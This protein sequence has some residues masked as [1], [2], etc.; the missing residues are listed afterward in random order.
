M[1]LGRFTTE[2]QVLNHLCKSKHPR[3]S[4]SIINRS[5]CSG[6][7]W[8]LPI[9]FLFSCIC[10]LVFW[11]VC[12][13]FSAF[14]L[15]ERSVKNGIS[16]DHILEFI[17]SS[18]SHFSAEKKI[19]MLLAVTMT[20]SLCKWQGQ[21]LV[22][23]MRSLLAYSWFVGQKKNPLWPTKREFKAA[24][25]SRQQILWC[26]CFNR[27][28][29]CRWHHFL[30]M[31]CVEITQSPWMCLTEPLLRSTAGLDKKKKKKLIH[32]LSHQKTSKMS[33]ERWRRLS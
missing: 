18:L 4:Q 5:G 8:L 20:E 30:R 3:W 16:S 6:C 19:N 31:G 29:W 26:S 28:L 17:F 22:S 2:I 9:F 10:W 25:H 21:W 33:C 24:S 23:A 7:L 15:A 14:T 11:A 1:Q 27:I 32:S 13:L 12:S